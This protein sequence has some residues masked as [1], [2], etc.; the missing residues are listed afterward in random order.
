MNT[1]IAVLSELDKVEPENGASLENQG[2]S[3]WALVLFLPRRRGEVLEVSPGL[4][5]TLQAGADDQ[6]WENGQNASVVDT[7]CSPAEG[8]QRHR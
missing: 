7:E 5:L 2:G 8:D 1:E 3:Q 6:G 4:D